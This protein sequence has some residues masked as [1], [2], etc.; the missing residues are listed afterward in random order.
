[1]T[2]YE[3]LK[4]MI[5]NRAAVDTFFCRMVEW[6][7]GEDEYCDWVCPFAKTCKR[8]KSGFSSWLDEKHVTP[9]P[10]L[11]RYRDVKNK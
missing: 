5:D 4:T 8:G 1:M 11:V 6:T 2:N 10:D 9:L 3:Y 7:I